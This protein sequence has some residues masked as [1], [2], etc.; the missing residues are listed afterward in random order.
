MRIGHMGIALVCI[1]VA[2]VWS[3]QRILLLIATL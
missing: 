3:V 1:A 2:A